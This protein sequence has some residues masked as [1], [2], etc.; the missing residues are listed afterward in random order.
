[1]LPNS[2]LLAILGNSFFIL[3]AIMLPGGV[4]LAFWQND[5]TWLYVSL[6]SLILFMA[7]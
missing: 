2:R 4:A 1:M 6:V 7:G 3:L 5:A